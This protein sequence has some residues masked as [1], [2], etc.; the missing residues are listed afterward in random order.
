MKKRV[1][2][3]LLA[4]C[5][6]VSMLVMPASAAGSNTAVQTAVTLGAFSSEDDVSA[7]LTRGGLAKLLV[8]FSAYRDSANTQGTTGTLYTDVKT[9]NAWA[10]YIRIAVQQGWMSGYTDGS[11]RPDNAVTLEEACTAVLKLLGYD[12]TTLSGGFPAAQLNKASSLGLRLNLSAAQGQAMT[13]ED[14]A[15]L[16]YNALTADT[17]SGSVYGTTLGFTVTSGQ[18][19]VSSILL[20]SLEGPFVANGGESLP[21]TPAAV[22]RNDSL[23]TSAQLN[24]Y[25]V[26]YYNASAKTVWIYSRKAAGRITAVS[27]SASAPTSVTVAGTSYTI[28]SSSVAPSCPA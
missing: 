21:F 19:D 5:I 8:A 9:G 11:F 10:P 7:S 15:V 2:A 4:V 23:T 25:D 28:A 26:Y 16:L 20:N 17:A 12:V 22:Y 24:A 27:P 13:R 3:L 6:S 14:G 18:V 1:L